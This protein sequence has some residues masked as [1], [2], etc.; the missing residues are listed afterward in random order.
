MRLVRLPRI[1]VWIIMSYSLDF[2]FFL[3]PF[4]FK[5]I[6]FYIHLTFFIFIFL[7]PLFLCLFS[8]LGF[9]W[10]YPFL[11]HLFS[12][13]FLAAARDLR[14]LSSQTRDQTSFLC[15]ETSESQ[16]LDYQGVPCHF[17]WF[18][19]LLFTNIFTN[20]SYYYL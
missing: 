17:F 7:I 19:I 6:H 12:F 2:F 3:F 15:S 8:T 18:Y 10:I 14:E 11:I 4:L 13:S 1:L 20:I 5:L 9:V 16:P